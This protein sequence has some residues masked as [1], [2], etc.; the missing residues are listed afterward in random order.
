MNQERKKLKVILCYNFIVNQVTVTCFLSL[1][2]AKDSS[3][4][5]C[6]TKVIEFGPMNNFSVQIRIVHW[7]PYDITSQTL[8]LDDT[9]KSTDESVEGKKYYSRLK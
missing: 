6:V 8:P 1:D 2:I 4:N 3:V 7:I 9:I 5:I